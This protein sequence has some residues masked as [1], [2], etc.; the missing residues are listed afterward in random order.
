MRI[1]GSG[2]TICL[3]V[4]NTDTIGV[5]KSKVEAKEGIPPEYNRLWF[6]S[7]WLQENRRLRDYNIKAESTL[8]LVVNLYGGDNMIIYIRTST[9]KTFQIQ[10]SR[11]E[12]MS[13]IKEKVWE[14]DGIPPDQQ[15]YVFNGVQLGEGV[16]L[17]VYNIRDGSIIC[18]VLRLRGGYSFRG[19]RVCVKYFKT[20]RF[21]EN[22]H[23]ITVADVKAEIEKLESYPVAIQRLVLKGKVL[24]DDYVLGEHDLELVLHMSSSNEKDRKASMA[25]NADSVNA[26]D[27]KSESEDSETDPASSSD[28]DNEEGPESLSEEDNE[29]NP[30]SS[31]EEYKEENP[32]S[33]S[34]EYKEENPKSSSEED[35]EENPESSSEEYK[36]ENPESSSEEYK[37]ENPESSSEED[38]EEDPES[39]SNEDKEDAESSSDDSETSCDN[40][41]DCEENPP[42][43]IKLE[44][45]TTKNTST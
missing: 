8:V 6:T 19:F 36:E 25:M 33:L 12:T 27:K 26:S 35:N 17:A 21:P 42:K 45:S 20:L 30:E 32:E 22:C 28:E 1:L 13:D 14:R 29:E 41:T 44:P 3:Q 23:L 9:G 37:E 40:E 2:K 38:N 31:S 24:G 4:K 11:Y 10:T 5:V 39:S 34:E 15:R 18:L 43:R 16:P 7:K